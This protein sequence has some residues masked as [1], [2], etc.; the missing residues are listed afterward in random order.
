MKQIECVC[1]FAREREGGDD[2]GDV[3]YNVLK[4]VPLLQYGWPVV[5]H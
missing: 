5:T 4:V 3:C 1:V 2:N